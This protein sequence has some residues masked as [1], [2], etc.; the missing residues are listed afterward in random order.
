MDTI[1][2]YIN[3]ICRR[4]NMEIPSMLPPVH[5][6]RTEYELFIQ[7]AWHITLQKLKI[8]ILLLY[9]CLGNDHC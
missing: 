4:R 9:L 7:L 2:F 6:S 3:A 5:K 8:E 1:T